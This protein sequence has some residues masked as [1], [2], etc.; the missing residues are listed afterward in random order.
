MDWVVIW[1]ICGIISAMIGSRKGEGCGAF[2][3]G[4]LLGPFGILITIFSKGNR[5]ECPFCKELIHREATVCPNCQREVAADKLHNTSEPG[6]APPVSSVRKGLLSNTER[7][8]V[9][10]IFVVIAF[11]VL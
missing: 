5:K 7:L 6:S 10:A 2:I 4:V 3:I 11:V 9:V 8:I 1:F